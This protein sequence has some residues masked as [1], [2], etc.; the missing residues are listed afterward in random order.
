MARVTKYIVYVEQGI[1]AKPMELAD[2]VITHFVKKELDI[3]QRR[4]FLVAFTHA[5]TDE[6]KLKVIDQWIAVRDVVTFPFRNEG[7]EEHENQGIE[8]GVSV[9]NNSDSEPDAGVASDGSDTQH[10]SNDEGDDGGIDNRD[11][12]AV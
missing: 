9:D 6:A 3:A 10:G 11:S 8:G 4:R 7:A 1:M 12:D 2:A 5:P